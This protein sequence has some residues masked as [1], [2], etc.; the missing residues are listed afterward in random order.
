MPEPYA[1]DG[2][3]EMRI[4]NLMIRN[5]GPC[6]RCSVVYLNWEKCCKVEDGGAFS[7]LAS[8]RS[9]PGKGVAFGM[10]YQMEILDKPAYE[11]FIPSE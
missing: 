2:L 10:Y 7:T 3:F 9:I 11:S 4:G 5:V 1:E 8:Y 6:W